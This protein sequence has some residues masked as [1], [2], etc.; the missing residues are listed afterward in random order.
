MCCSSELPF[1]IEAQVRAPGKALHSLL[2]SDRVRKDAKMPTYARSPTNKRPAVNA[3]H[4][5]INF[6]SQVNRE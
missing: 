2:H 4:H 3:S 1:D 5:S 6:P